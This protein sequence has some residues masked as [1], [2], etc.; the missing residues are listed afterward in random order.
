[1]PIMTKGYL[2]CKISDLKYEIRMEEMKH[3][4]AI[5]NREEATADYYVKKIIMLKTLVNEYVN[6]L[7]LE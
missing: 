4:Q 5:E 6:K 7:N 1:M 2:I 3:E